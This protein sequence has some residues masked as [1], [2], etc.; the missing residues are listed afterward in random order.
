MNPIKVS[1]VIPVYNTSEYLTEAVNS[2]SQ[3][4]LR[5]IEIIAINDGSQDN[6]LDILEHLSKKDTR[7]KVISFERNVGVSVCRNK[8]IELAKGEFIYFFD[9]D[10]ILSIDCLE[11]CYQKMLDEASDFLIFDGVSFF[12][13]EMKTGF[14]PN[15]ER[16][17]YLTNKIYTGKE[18]LR[19]LNQHNG[20]SCSVCLCFIR[21]D[22]LKTINLEFLPG[23]LYEDV[24]FTIILYLSA[25][26]VGFIKRSF[27]RRRIRPNSTMTSSVTQKNI[28]Y[29]LKVCKEILKYKKRFPDSESK[30]LLNLQVRNVL[31]FLIKTLFH[32][33]QI[34]LLL[35]NNYTIS[36]LIFQTFKL[37]N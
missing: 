19:E 18:I 6:S 4:T 17:Q 33:R 13:G 27:F 7:I 23:V 26:K 22:Y 36:L 8:G 2:I 35:A 30:R 16:T 32:S 9:S 15:Y 21:I 34:G 3:Q 14:N 10:D 20:Y 5:D 28:D 29:R 1:V 37:K 11:L 31:K 24:L 12:H 25:Q